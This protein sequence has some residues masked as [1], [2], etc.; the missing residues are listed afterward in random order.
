MAKAMKVEWETGDT[1]RWWESDRH[2]HA[3]ATVLKVFKNGK[4]RCEFPGPMG[5]GF[6]EYTVLP[7][8]IVRY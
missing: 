6:E 3:K 4:V 5:R 8:Q 1:V 2:P 7:H